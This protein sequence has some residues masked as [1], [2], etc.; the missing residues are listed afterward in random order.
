VIVPRYVSLEEV[1]Q[2][3][4]VDPSEQPGQSAAMK[5]VEVME[6]GAHSF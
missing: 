1:G 3:R 4:P 2:W 6:Q 5:I